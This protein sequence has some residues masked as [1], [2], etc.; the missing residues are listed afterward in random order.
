MKRKAYFLAIGIIIL[1][2]LHS[3]S[4]SGEEYKV[5]ITGYDISI[6]GERQDQV[7]RLLESFPLK[8][9][10][11]FEIA[12]EIDENL[13]VKREFE[14]YFSTKD[15][16]L[17]VVEPVLEWGKIH[18]E[19]QLL[20]ELINDV[21]VEFKAEECPKAWENKM[22][23][24]TLGQQMTRDEMEKNKLQNIEELKKIAKE[25]NMSQWEFSLHLESIEKHYANLNKDLSKAKE[26]G[27]QV[28]KL[29]KINKLYGTGIQVEI[30]RGQ[31]ARTSCHLRTI[32]IERK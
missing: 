4:S 21:I 16:I 14:F 22:K 29:G 2:T 7:T 12:K 20:P 17:S 23:E 18:L 32:L 25:R 9:K 10:T 11:I 1:F 5:T 15:N 3:F 28:F 8:G 13:T 31:K 6:E 27:R 24:L 19:M 30:P 26:E